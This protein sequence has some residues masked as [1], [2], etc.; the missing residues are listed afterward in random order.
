MKALNLRSLYNSCFL[1]IVLLL[2]AC[3]KNENPFPERIS[4][5]VN[6]KHV[7][8][9]TD[10]EFDTITYTTA[11][12]NAYEITRLEYYISEIVLHSD[13]LGD[14][15]SSNSFYINANSDLYNSFLLTNVPSGQYERIS[16]K[17]GLSPQY[18]V[19]YYLP[20]T[21]EN[22]SMAWPETMGGGYH[23]LKLEGHYLNNSIPEGFAIHLGSN[24]Y[25]ANC[26]LNKSCFLGYTPHEINLEMDVNEWFESPHTYDF[27]VDGT[28]TMGD[29]LLM[30]KIKENGYN[31]FD[32]Q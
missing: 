23:F 6:I 7:V 30:R 19:S 25:H 12:G 32:I 4:L 5:K 1:S 21:A 20:N 31:T 2:A 17:I 26:S 28:Y 15:V 18:N 13:F 11:A 9:S 22:V 16:F 29:T 14:Y 27:Q 8:D 10:L 3:S 24:N